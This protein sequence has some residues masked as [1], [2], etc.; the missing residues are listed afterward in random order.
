MDISLMKQVLELMR[1]QGVDHFK[2]EGLEVKFSP[3][4]GPSVLEPTAEDRRS[5]LMELLKAD[6]GDREADELWST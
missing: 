1:S 4:N 2:F 5:A 6:D 3:H